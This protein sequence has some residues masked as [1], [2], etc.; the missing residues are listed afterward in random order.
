L[1]KAKKSLRLLPGSDRSK[2]ISTIDR[3][4]TNPFPRNCKKLTAQ[5][6]YRLRVG[7]YRILYIANT[8]ANLITIVRIAHRKDIY[9]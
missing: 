7:I 2:V 3:L 1:L 6:G 8:K 4:A 9:R 5:P